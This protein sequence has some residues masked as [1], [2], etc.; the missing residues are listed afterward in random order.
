MNTRLE[1]R[2]RAAAAELNLA[3]VDEEY[4]DPF[5]WDRYG[6]RGRR[7][8]VEDGMHHFNYVAEA[9]AAASPALIVKY[10]RWLRSVLV[11]RGMC[12]EHLAEGLR[13]RGRLV[14]ERWQD[15]A[16]AVAAFAA[17]EAALRYT[18]GAAAAL[19]QV[20][21]AGAAAAVASRCGVSVEAAT[22]DLR[23]LSSYTG[24]AL[25]AEDAEIL[26]AHV[27]WRSGFDR[28]RGRPAGYT[29]TVLAAL[30]GALAV[31]PARALVEAARERLA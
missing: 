12:S 11:A 23:A 24:D 15:A 30:A 17:A 20:E 28:R 7:F 1:A 4:R 27:Q 26:L 22:H 9:V 29:A 8:A 21:L 5:W 18:E 25:A 31:A 19:A 14:G 16:P 3:A 2:L 10:A 6:E 13:I